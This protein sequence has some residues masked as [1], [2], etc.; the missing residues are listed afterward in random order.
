VWVLGEYG[1]RISEAP[2]L[3]EELVPTYPELPASLKL[4]LLSAAMKLLFK[5]APEMQPV[6]G[7][8]L[9]TALD[10]SSNVDVRDRALLYYR[11]LRQHLPQVR[12]SAPSSHTSLARKPRSTQ[13][14]QLQ[15]RQMFM[16][17]KDP[18]GAFTEETHTELYV[19]R[20]QRTRARRV[21][22]AR[23]S[24]SLAAIHPGGAAG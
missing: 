6:M 2:Y 21:F 9:R 13:H 23:F 18:I 4:Q 20:Q 10:D 14:P 17:E 8:L 16:I 11:L 7:Q 1:E 15:A 19:R 3:L 12:C 24:Q 5:R 22:L